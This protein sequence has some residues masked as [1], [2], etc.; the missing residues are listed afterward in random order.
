MPIYNDPS[1]GVNIFYD[2]PPG[3]YPGAPVIVL[4]HGVIGSRDLWKR[5]IPYLV[6]W[7]RVVNIQARGHKGSKGAGA[8]DLWDVADDVIG[9]LKQERIQQASLVGLS[10]GGMT[11]LRVALKAPEMVRSMVLLGCNAGAEPWF[12]LN[13]K[14]RPM[15]F[16]IRHSGV[17][18]LEWLLGPIMFGPTALKEQPE[19]MREFKEVAR[20]HQKHDLA[21][22]VHAVI[23]R[24][25]ITARLRDIR[26]PALVL[27][28]DE[29]ETTKRKAA[30]EIVSGLPDAR[31]EPL[32]Q[33]GHLSALERPELVAEKIISFVR[34]HT[35]Q[36]HA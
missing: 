11:A 18:W 7:F 35:G 6:K 20:S 16:I 21:D 25:S 29:D 2:L 10:M 1:R 31:L 5:V 30:E 28:G 22:T 27:H 15:E 3:P 14:Y 26:C 17:R 4:L 23:T 34:G 8:C 9:I 19:L 13:F 12:L 32:S 33:T 36:A 24:E